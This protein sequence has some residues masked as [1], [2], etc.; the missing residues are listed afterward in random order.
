[1]SKITDVILEIEA[2]GDRLCNNYDPEV[3]AYADGL[4]I[5][6]ICA[7]LLKGDGA[8]L[9]TLKEIAEKDLIGSYDEE[10]LANQLGKELLSSLSKISQ[11]AA[12]V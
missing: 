4:E 5:K 2:I 12:N 6:E 3:L 7:D 10:V 11:A 8:R 1:M 9:N